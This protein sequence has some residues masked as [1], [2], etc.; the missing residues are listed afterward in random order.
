MIATENGYNLY[1]GGNGG[2]NPVHAQLLATDIDEDTV[3][4][5]LDRYIMYYI[6]TAD[7]LERTAPWQAKLPSGKNG[8]GPIEHLK[9]VIIEDSL[10]ICDELDRRMQHLVDTY[11]DEWAEV[12]KDPVRRNKFKQ[13]VNTDDNQEREEMIEFIDQRGQVRPTDW[14]PDGSPQ[15]NWVPDDNDVFARSEKSWVAVGK[16]ADFAP[17]VGSAILYG[18][19]QLAVFNNA[20]R[21]EWYCTQNMC[22][23]KQAFVLSQGII[24]DAEGVSKVACPLHKK[25]FGLEDGKQL[26]GDL[27]LITFPVKID[28]DDVL[29]ELPAEAEVDA[30]LGTHGLRVHSGCE[31]V[32]DISGTALEA[33][34]LS[35]VTNSNVTSLV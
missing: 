5:Y 27:S 14:M 20:K 23:H 17:N 13:F 3:I 35:G 6:L 4:R 34:I 19:S 1:V 2:V 7:R 26:D 29:V 21:G 28:G 24:G 25:Q 18:D 33:E 22:P 15:T 9:E 12:V 31:G 32:K 16:V 8:G 30:I 10:G 11:H